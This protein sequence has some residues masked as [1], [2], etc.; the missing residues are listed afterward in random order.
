MSPSTAASA[1]RDGFVRADAS[2]TSLVNQDFAKVIAAMES[3][4]PKEF[5]ATLETL[6]QRISNAK[7]LLSAREQAADLPDDTPSG[8]PSPATSN[9]SESPKPSEPDQ[10]DSTDDSGSNASGASDTPEPKPTPEP[11]KTDSTS[12]EDSSDD[13]DANEDNPTLGETVKGW[14]GDLKDKLHN[15]LGRDD[16]GKVNFQPAPSQLVPAT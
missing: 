14:V 6:K 11:S 8:Q 15:P 3:G 5:D 2:L 12:K 1:I 9:E 7:D 13:D 4:T 10:T 16:N